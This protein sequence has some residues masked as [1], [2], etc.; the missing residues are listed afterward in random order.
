M[1]PRTVPPMTRAPLRKRL[2]TKSFLSKPSGAEAA[3]RIAGDWP[4]WAAPPETRALGREGWAKRRSLVGAAAVL[5]LADRRCLT[6]ALAFLTG[7][8]RLRAGALVAEAAPFGA[9]SSL[10]S[11][12]ISERLAVRFLGAG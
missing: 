12:R 1:R 4:S 2:E 6:G 3:G 9:L 5:P 7:A 10:S 11:R 8:V